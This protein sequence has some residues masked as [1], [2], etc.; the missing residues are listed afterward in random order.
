MTFHGGWRVAKGP[1]TQTLKAFAAEVR[2]VRALDFSSI[3]AAV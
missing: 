1:T 2:A 3:F